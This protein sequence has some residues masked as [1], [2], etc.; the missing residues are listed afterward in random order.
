[1]NKQIRKKTSILVFKII[2][3]LIIKGNIIFFHYKNK[4][5]IEFLKNYNNKTKIFESSQN[6]NIFKA[7]EILTNYILLISYFGNSHS[8]S[9]KS[10]VVEKD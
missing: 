6:I 4:I 1:M 3:L 9:H 8:I 10:E 2:L 7:F 5:K